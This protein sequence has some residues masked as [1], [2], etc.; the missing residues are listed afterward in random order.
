MPCREIKGSL[1]E[2]DGKMGMF[3]EMEID[4]PEEIFPLLEEKIQT[5][6][7][8]RTGTADLYEKIRAGGCPGVDRVVGMGEALNFDTVWDRK[9]IIDI[10][11]E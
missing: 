11:S 6:V 1:A 9:D 2:Y 3:F 7:T 8:S 5:V 4:G 10:L